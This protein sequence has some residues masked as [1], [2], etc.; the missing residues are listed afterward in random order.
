MHQVFRCPQP[1]QRLHSPCKH[2]CQKATCGE[3]C[4]KCMIVLDSILLPCGHLRDGVY[5]HQTQDLTKVYCKTSV[6]KTV[7]GCNHLVEVQCSQVTECASFRCSSPCN[8][9]LGCGHQCPGT[10]GTCY[11]RQPDSVELIRHLDCPKICG[12]PFSTCNHNCPRLC[13]DEKS[14]GVCLSLCE[15]CFLHIILIQWSRPVYD[16]STPAPANMKDSDILTCIGS[17]LSFSLSAKMSRGVCAL[18]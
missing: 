12:R 6:T 13:H 4:G 8:I 1:C 11:R 15:V 7:P 14:C 17:M 18:Y 10:C 16:M 9:D 5:C 2:A 3:D